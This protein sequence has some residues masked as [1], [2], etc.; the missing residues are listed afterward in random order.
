VPRTANVVADGPGTLLEVPAVTLRRLMRAPEVNRLLL[1]T[2]TARLATLEM[3]DL[4]RYA[5]AGPH[6][7]ADLRASGAQAATPAA[8]DAAGSL[9]SGDALGATDVTDAT[10]EIASTDGPRTG[11]ILADHVDA[12]PAPRIQPDVAST[13][14]TVSGTRAPGG[15]PRTQP[16]AQGRRA[17]NGGPRRVS[18]R[19]RRRR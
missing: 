15:R 1:S 8:A 18:A 3:I 6:A 17:T 12:S 9:E 10:G 2:M 13:E 19:P 11:A 16:P 4:P 5:F 7:L 14:D